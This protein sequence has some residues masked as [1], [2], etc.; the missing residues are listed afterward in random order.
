MATGA[1][2]K[3]RPR[4]VDTK[5][6]CLSN[7][8]PRSQTLGGP[9]A[10]TSPLWREHHRRDRRREEQPAPTIDVTSSFFLPLGALRAS[11]TKAHTRSHRRKQATAIRHSRS[12]ESHLLETAIRAPLRGIVCRAQSFCAIVG[13]LQFCDPRLT[14]AVARC[15]TLAAARREAL[16]LCGCGA[17]DS[18]SSRRRPHTFPPPRREPPRVPAVCWRGRQAPIHEGLDFRFDRLRRARGT[19]SAS[20]FPQSRA[21]PRSNGRSLRVQPRRALRPSRARSRASAEPERRAVAPEIQAM[22]CSGPGQIATRHIALA[23][24]SAPVQGIAGRLHSNRKP[25]NTHCTGSVCVRNSPSLRNRKRVVGCS[26][27]RCFDFARAAAL[28]ARPP[29]SNDLAS[30][31]GTRIDPSFLWVDVSDEA[32]SLVEYPRR[33]VEIGSEMG[34]FESPKS[35]SVHNDR[36]TIH[37]RPPTPSCDGVML[38]AARPPL[39]LKPGGLGGGPPPPRPSRSGP[40]R[41]SKRMLRFTAPSPQKVTITKL[42]SS[43]SAD[44]GP[45]ARVSSESRRSL[46]PPLQPMAFLLR[47]RRGAS[48]ITVELFLVLRPQPPGQDDSETLTIQLA[49][50]SYSISSRGRPR[51]GPS[52]SYGRGR[53]RGTVARS[54]A[55]HAPKARRSRDPEPR[56]NE[57]RHEL[58]R[59][60]SESTLGCR[61][62][63]SRFSRT[64]PFRIAADLRAAGAWLRAPTHSRFAASTNF[65]SCPLPSLSSSWSCVREGEEHLGERGTSLDRLCVRQ[66]MLLASTTTPAFSAMARSAAFPRGR[67]GCSSDSVGDRSCVF[68]RALPV[69]SLLRSLITEPSPTFHHP[70]TR[71][72]ASN[73]LLSGLAKRR[74]KRLPSLLRP[75]RPEVARR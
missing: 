68:A 8:S 59:T 22:R 62:I 64:D 20:S 31:P 1:A 11:E 73:R 47:P 12:F 21:A 65:I 7:R 36:E 39:S 51:F 9:P 30:H 49:G 26:N 25:T 29:T 57:S 34:Q 28:Q 52:L 48:T 15:R 75:T 37:R 71:L 53:P 24:G 42:L 3:M 60:S 18:E 23:V 55:A 66:R 35:S 61:T 63:Q 50:S 14:V 40:D 32:F 19:G 27:V 72:T 56:D 17:H 46:P 58:R 16:L 43:A 41:H 69:D 74:R 10:R 54:K 6:R 38:Q 5:R 13:I 44:V 70:S 2:T 45:R 33:L 4:G 67:H